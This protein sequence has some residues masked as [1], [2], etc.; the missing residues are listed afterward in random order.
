MSEY[1]KLG[2][3]MQSGVAAKMALDPSESTPKHLRVGVNLA[4]VDHAALVRILLEK[5]LFTEAEYERALTDQM[6]REV[7]AYRD[8]FTA[9]GITVDFA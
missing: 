9:R 4:M 3:A 6:A 8:W 2:H 7:Q 5:G 1:L